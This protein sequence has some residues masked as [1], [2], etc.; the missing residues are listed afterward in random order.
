M[1]FISA[2]V[3]FMFRVAIARSRTHAHTQKQKSQIYISIGNTQVII[4]LSKEAS[5][6]LLTICFNTKGPEEDM[7]SKQERQCTYK[8]NI[9]ARSRNNCCSG[10]A[11]RITYCECV[12]VALVIQHAK[13]MR[14][15]I[16]SSVACL[17]VT[18]FSTLF[19]K[20][21]NFRKKVI[22]YKI[23]LL[24]FSTTSV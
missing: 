9:E 17:A 4:E 11:I 19:H 13:R 8:S 16:L 7:K 21:Y 15:V 5:L 1:E 23:C 14:C 10:K 3:A 22:E 24:I 6:N 2:R 20:R 18:Y 12:S